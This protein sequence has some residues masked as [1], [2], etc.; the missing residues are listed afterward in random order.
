ME[1]D[2]DYSKLWKQFLNEFTFIQANTYHAFSET[3]L[4]LL[5]KYTTCIPASTIN[6]PDVSLYDHL[7]TTAALAVCLY[8]V[9]QSEENPE[10]PF[11]LIGADLSGIQSYIYQVVSKYASKNLKGRSFYLRILSDSVVRFLLKELGL[12]QANV[13]Y[14]SGGGFY[15]IAPNTKVISKNTS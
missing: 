15:I 12:F 11:L 1:G 9:R 7:K 4:N 5:F 10:D 6:F 2:P 3:L 14:N 8:D 13:V